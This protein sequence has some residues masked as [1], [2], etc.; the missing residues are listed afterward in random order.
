MKENQK[1][2]S[3]R[4]TTNANKNYLSKMNMLTNDSSLCSF[5]DTIL[6]SP[7]QNESKELQK[8]TIRKVMEKNDA[9]SIE[10]HNFS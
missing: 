10:N 6:H 4:N 5:Q 2:S 9:K 8:K 3:K 1:N 7:Y